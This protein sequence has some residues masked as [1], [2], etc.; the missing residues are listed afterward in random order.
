MSSFTP[1]TSSSRC[2]SKRRPPRPRSFAPLA[3]YLKHGARH[4]HAVFID[5]PE[6]HFHPR[7]QVVLARALTQMARAVGHVA[8]ASHSEFL[9]NG[10]SNELMAEYAGDRQAGT[11]PVRRP[12]RAAFYEFRPRAERAGVTVEALEFDPSTGLDV[13]QFSSVANETI[14]Q[15]VGLYNA[16]HA[17][18]AT[19][20]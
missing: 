14:D 6:A 8:I 1:T 20:T 7:S 9:V 19:T 18:T 11:L 5:E 15:A 16:I 13:E 4:G 3:L 10:L 2:R 17:S 12:L